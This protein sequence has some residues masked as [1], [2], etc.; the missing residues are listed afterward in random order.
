MKGPESHTIK[1][2][3]SEVAGKYDR[4]N[5]ILSLGIHH[6]WR[7]QLVKKSGATPG[8]HI[9]DCATGTGDVAMAF[10]KYLKGQG[11]VTG[12]D[13][14]PD[15][16]KHA[17]V[18]AQKKGYSIDFQV[19]DVTNLPFPENSFDIVSISF[20]IRNVENPLHGL[21]EMTRVLKPGGRLLILEFGQVQWPLL[22]SCYNWYS[23]S[24]LPK[25]GGWITQKPQ[26]YDYLQKSSA[27]FPCGNSFIELMKSVDSLTGLEFQTLHGGIAYLYR[28]IKQN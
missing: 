20:G 27:E 15:M 19:A 3:F 23:Q 6:L 7:K 26:A 9:L 24:L 25:I 5:Q 12:I 11:I 10:Q 14:C 18:K 21:A 2:I 17:P 22:N 8:C 16:L 28:G 13:F 1:S 4:A